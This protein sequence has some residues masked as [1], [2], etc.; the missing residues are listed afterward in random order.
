MNSMNG[1]RQ[2]GTHHSAVCARRV[3]MLIARNIAGTLIIE[4]RHASAT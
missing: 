1:N 3:A 2:A 4:V